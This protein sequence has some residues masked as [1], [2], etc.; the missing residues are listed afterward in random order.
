MRVLASFSYWNKKWEMWALEP[1]LSPLVNSRYK[2]GNCCEFG[3]LQEDPSESYLSNLFLWF[4]M[5]QN[6]QASFWSRVLEV[7]LFT[8][9]KTDFFSCFDLH[10][11]VFLCSCASCKLHLMF[12]S[13]KS[14][15]KLSA[16][17]GMQYVILGDGSHEW[18]QIG[19]LIAW[20]ENCYQMWGWNKGIKC[21]YLVSP[22]TTTTT[23]ITE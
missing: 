23:R 13:C 20:W 18:L 17:P 16:D 9:F 10:I 12:W 14:A 22:S 7:N 21:T 19:N 11:I 6:T 8:L 4:W 15:A 2:C 5:A 3:P 1:Y